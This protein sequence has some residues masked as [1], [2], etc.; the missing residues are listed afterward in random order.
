M[1]YIREGSAVSVCTF[2]KNTHAHSA[3][4]SDM[5]VFS[6]PVEHARKDKDDVV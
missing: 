6:L 4:L 5:C 2:L 3:P 1:N